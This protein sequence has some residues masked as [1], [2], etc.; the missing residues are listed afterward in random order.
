MSEAVEVPEGTMTRDQFLRWTERQPRGRFELD[1]GR[2]VAMAPERAAHADAKALAW[3][4]LRN[5]I[6][7]AG[8]PCRAYVDG[9]AVAVDDDTSYEPDALVNGGDALEPDALAASQPVI[10]VEVTSPS[11]SRVDLDT[12][13]VGYFRVPSIRHYLIVHL[14]KRVVI[15]HRRR[16]ADRIE[17]AILGSGEITLDPPGLVVTVE[18]LLPQP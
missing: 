5:A 8:A 12:K 10:V 6:E 4:A 16:D 13:F 14:A 7:R 18:D 17:S 3:R 15:H 9:L 11:N 1:A 2:V